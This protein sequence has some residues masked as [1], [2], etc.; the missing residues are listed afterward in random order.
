MP[1]TYKDKI[2]KE[3]EEIPEEK[4]PKIYRIIHLLIAELESKTKKAGNRGS[5]KGIGKGC[6]IEEVLFQDAK[7]ARLPDED[8]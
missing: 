8:K 3:L 5:L 2:L 7:K 6:Q 1:L 4:M